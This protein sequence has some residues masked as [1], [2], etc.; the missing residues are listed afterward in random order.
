VGEVDKLKAL[1]RDLV[2]ENPGIDRRGLKEL[3]VDLGKDAWS[4]ADLATLLR[5]MPEIQSSVDENGRH[6]YFA[7]DPDEPLEPDPVAE[8]R[9][10]RGHDF[11]FPWQERAISAWRAAGSCGVIEAVTGSGKTRVA[12][13]AIVEDRAAGFACVVLVPTLDLMRQWHKELN[14]HAARVGLRLSIGQLGGDHHDELGYHDVLIATAASA[15]NTWLLPDS[16]VG[17]IV[18]D[19]V[20]HY[21]AETWSKGLEEEFDHRLGLTA[22]YERDDDGVERVLDPYFESVVYQ[23]GYQEALRDGVIAPF[24]VIFAG[25]RFDYSERAQYLDAA[26]KASRYRARLINDYGLTAEPFGL[27]MRAVQ[28]LRH[29]DGGEASRWAGFYLSAFTK[30]RALLAE[31]SG[32]LGLIEGLAPAVKRAERTMVF[33]NT[34][35]AAHQVVDGLA[36]QGVAGRVLTADMDIDER[37]GV[38]AGFEDGEHELVA[39]PRLLDEGVDVPSADLA[40]V[41]STSR[42]RRQLIQRL[43]RVIRPKRD[44]REARIVVLFVEDTPEDPRTGA[45]E[46][47]LDEVE[48][49]A[50][51]VVVFDS[52]VSAGELVAHLAPGG[53]SAAAIPLARPRPGPAGGALNKDVAAAVAQVSRPRRPHRE[54]DLWAGR[55]IVVST[56]EWFVQQFYRDLGTLAADFHWTIDGI[57]LDLIEDG[58]VVI[59]D[60]NVQFHV[61]SDVDGSTAHQ[62][63]DLIRVQWAPGEVPIM[64]F[65]AMRND[66]AR[67]LGADLAYEEAERYRSPDGLELNRAQAAVVRA[68]LLRR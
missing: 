12:L 17:L 1:L 52:G 34:K 3:L 16:Q 21:G 39:A 2:A 26:S 35:V 63:C 53:R 62:L 24:R 15:S 57:A 27:F 60:R 22:T 61:D 45:N 13:Q 32:K 40:F 33:A 4:R 38:F 36:A 67:R 58:A 47:F 56:A 44:G 10:Q 31:A 41:L 46:D 51:E 25:C 20:H 49:A 19:E 8:E 68:R 14:R 11:L 37:R 54:Y 6:H 18:A 50:Q 30:R 59:I 29:S 43:G 65:G 42:S 55:I 66:V 5:L 7:K 23:V 9:A 28:R 48:A 64:I